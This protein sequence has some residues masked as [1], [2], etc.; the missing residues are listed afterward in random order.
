[1]I[2]NKYSS[3]S[4][5]CE[6]Y[7]S[8]S[9][10]VVDMVHSA[11][12]GKRLFVA[13]N[14][15]TRAQV[16]AKMLRKDCGS[17]LK[18][19]LITA[20]DKISEEVQSF[21]ADVARK[22]L[23]YD[24]VVASPAIGTGIDITFPGD[25]AE[26]D[27]VYGFFNAGINSH[28][29]V[30]Q[31]LGRVRNP[32]QVKVWICGRKSHFETDLEAVKLDI[33]ETGDSHTAI[34]SFKDG[35]PV[36]NMDHPLLTLQA[37]AYCAQ[38]ASQNALKDLFI[39]HKER[40]GW[41]IV[42]AAKNNAGTEAITQKIRVLKD[43][44]EAEVREG[45]LNA[46]QIDE[47]DWKE[48]FD[49]QARGE[50]I[51]QAASLEMKRF[52]VQNFYN[53]PVTDDLIELD[54]DGR[55]RQAVILFQKLGLWRPATA[56]RLLARWNSANFHIGERLGEVPLR[57]LAAALVSAGLISDAGLDATRV[58]TKGDLGGFL[59]FCDERRV[60]IER[61]L[62]INLRKDR[63]RD[64]IKTLNLF[65]EL[66]GLEIIPL[67]KSKKKGAAIYRYVLNKPQLDTLL[68]IITARQRP[69]SELPELLDPPRPRRRSG[70]DGVYQNTLTVFDLCP[71]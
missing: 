3:D 54:A 15:K 14:S 67:S 10:L 61:D 25:A 68:E 40:N 22:I 7:G 16:F 2:L 29:D 41:N 48:Y 8:P 11:R 69:R 6:L 4:R 60:T 21:L 9:Q 49:R 35:M 27:V 1:M 59:V 23:E 42:S 17:N 13:C 65:L 30:D 53:L 66:I 56:A 5:V 55:Y 34:E 18:V 32:K 33:V 20:E 51:G 24:V 39:R 71:V 62:G 38:R 43:E 31:Q 36:I 45:I 46:A 52:E 50:A 19:L 70:L 47:Y 37:S 12:T 63:D 28:Y 58:I 26:I 57:C 44:I 64:P